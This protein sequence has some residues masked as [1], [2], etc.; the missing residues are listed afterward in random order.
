MKMIFVLVFI[1]IVD[2]DY[3]IELIMGIYIKEL[4]GSFYNLL[5]N[6]KLYEIF[7][8]CIKNFIFKNKNYILQYNKLE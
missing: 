3:S 4:Q 2:M 8:N 5:E 7:F 1:R 6:R